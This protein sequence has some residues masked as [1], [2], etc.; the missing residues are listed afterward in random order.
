[1]QL[2]ALP[3][4]HD[5]LSCFRNSGYLRGSFDVYEVEDGIA[6][7]RRRQKLYLWL[8]WLLLKTHGDSVTRARNGTAGKWN[9][10][11]NMFGI[12][13]NTVV[14]PTHAGN[15][16]EINGMEHRSDFVRVKAVHDF[17]GIYI[18]WDVHVLRDIKFLRE[19][20]FKAIGGRQLG[21]EIN[22]GTFPSWRNAALTQIGQRL[23]R[24]PG[25]MLIMEQDA[26]A[27]G[28]WMYEDNVRLF[29]GH[30]TTTSN[31]EN[32][33]Q[34]DPL[35]SYEE[36]DKHER[37]NDFPDWA[38]DW[39]TTYMLHAFTPDRGGRKIEGYDHISPRY[40]LERQ[41]NFARAVYPIAKRMYDEG[42]VRIDDSYNG[43]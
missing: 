13:I 9:K 3:F 30:N 7:R 16:K 20:G 21:G 26:F 32:I 14:V 5:S 25:E 12:K 11:I 22:S 24:E 36:G 38:R 2:V 19:S 29:G 18:D 28:S 10:Y 35:P 15:G 43:M 23:V 39:S 27:P 1:M 17:G 34:G 40:V 31:L 6:L 37:P 42:L 33:A 41:S 4:A 8:L